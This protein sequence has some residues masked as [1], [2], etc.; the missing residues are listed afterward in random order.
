MPEREQVYPIPDTLQCEAVLNILIQKSAI[1]GTERLLL[2]WWDQN[3]VLLDGE[4]K[5]NKK[6]RFVVLSGHAELVLMNTLGHSV[7]TLTLQFTSPA[8]AV[9]FVNDYILPRTQ[10]ENYLPLA[11]R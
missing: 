9:D 3:L 11:L 2:R 10:N 6:K 8:A 4:E 1:P 7:R 5:G